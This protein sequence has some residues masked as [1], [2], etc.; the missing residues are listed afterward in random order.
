MTKNSKIPM[1]VKYVFVLLLVS[2]LIVAWLP[3]HWFL[4]DKAEEEKIVFEDNSALNPFMME[5]AERLAA[6]AKSQETEAI[7]EPLVALSEP[8]EEKKLSEGPKFLKKIVPLSWQEKLGRSEKT[9]IQALLECFKTLSISLVVTVV[10]SMIIAILLGFISVLSS[11]FGRF[12]NTVMTAVE[13]VPSILIA[14]F[15]YAPVAGALAK[16]EAGQATF[17]SVLVFVIAT[18]L[19]VLPEA[20]RSISIP[21]ADLYDK[22]YSISFRSYGFT[23]PRI[24]FVLMK[25]DIIKAAIKRVAAGIL[26]KTLVMDTSL[27]YVIQVGFGTAGQPSHP[28]PGGLIASFRQNVLSGGKNPEYFWATT[29]LVIMIS[30]AFLLLLKK[31]KEE[32]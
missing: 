16:A 8:A 23:K 27:G 4:S 11:G 7:E 6:E 22:K 18:T 31:D 26:L 21:L 2:P 9:F 19:T 20:I 29:V 12:L 30:V 3:P 13:S 28:S 25:M 32:A 5:E 10:A 15:L 1:I 17:T 24:L 14:L